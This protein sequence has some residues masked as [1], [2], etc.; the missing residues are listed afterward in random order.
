MRPVLS[1]LNDR[2]V[3][4]G[5]ITAFAD[6]G[7]EGLTACKTPRLAAVA[8]KMTGSACDLLARRAKNTEFKF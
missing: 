2:H 7:L 5:Q 4:D 3:P 8:P 6:F 1:G